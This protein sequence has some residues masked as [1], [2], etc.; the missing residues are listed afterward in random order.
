MLL[1]MGFSIK[2]AD[3]MISNAIAPLLLQIKSLE[4]ELMNL[5]ISPPL[6]QIK[7]LKNELM[8]LRMA[9]IQLESRFSLLERR[10][11]DSEQYSQRLNLIVDGVKIRGNETP[12]DIKAKVF[13]EI[14]HLGVEI[15]DIEIDRAHRIERP[16]K[17]QHGRLQQPVI[18]RFISWGARNLLYQARK[19]SSLRMRPHLTRRR[20]R[21]LQDARDKIDSYDHVREAVSYVF[22]D[23]NCTLQA[24]STD[25]K[26]YGFSTETEFDSVVNFI[27]GHGKTKKIH[28]EMD[29]KYPRTFFN[30]KDSALNS[31]L[32]LDAST[33]N[34]QLYSDVASPGSPTKISTVDPLHL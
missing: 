29:L 34:T 13:K 15:D 9:N 5:R 7:S 31:P 8:N 10:N 27:N 4:N 22:V 24:K 2:T 26:L 1:K 19:R 25:G 12:D 18:V 21:T 20:E 11:D 17:D 32:A 33:P 16:F 30:Q 28:P 23:R 14:D 3:E 6:L